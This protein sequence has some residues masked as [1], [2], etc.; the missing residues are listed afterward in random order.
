[1][2]PRD[3]ST[4]ARSGETSPSLMSIGS[5]KQARKERGSRGTTITDGRKWEGS[6]ARGRREVWEN[7]KLTFSLE[8]SN[9]ETISSPT[10][11]PRPP[12]KC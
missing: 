12:S 2:G 6:L 7:W 9:P 4:V 5:D 10:Q 8:A 1:M 11:H 3:V